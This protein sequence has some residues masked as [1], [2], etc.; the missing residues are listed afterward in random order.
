M[1]YAARGWQVVPL[2]WP[3][4]EKCSCGKADCPSPAKH[5]LTEHGLND[6]SANAQVIKAWWQRWP[7]ANVAIITGAESGLI[8]LDI[9]RKNGGLESKKLLERK[10]NFPLT[11]TVYTGGGGEHLFFRHPQNGR[12]FRNRARLGGYSGIDLRGD[13][14]YVVAVPSR[15][16]SGDSYA[17]KINP[18]NTKEV[19]AP[20]W[21]KKVIDE[22]PYRPSLAKTGTGVW[23]KLWS[24]VGEG[25]RNEVAA[26]L[27]GRL[28]GRGIAEEEAEAILRAWNIGN[29][30][31][32]TEKELEQVVL[33][34]SRAEAAKPQ[35]VGVMPAEFFLTAEI[36]R[37][38][39]I[40]AGGIIMEGSGVI[41]TG[42]SGVGKSLLTLEIAIRISKGLPLWEYEVDKPRQVLFIQKENPDYTIQTRLRRLCRGLEI[43]TVRKIHFAKRDFKADLNNTQDLRQ[44]QNLIEKLG[45]EL[46]ILDPL[47]SY[48]RVN[49]NDNIQMRQTL[50]HL[51]DISAATN[52]AW[53]I[54]HHEGKPQDGREGAWRFRGASSIRDW[55]DTM[56]GYTAKP[57]KE[58]KVL[59][60]LS[61]D[62]LRHG[63]E[64]ASLLLERDE[65]FVHQQTEDAANLVTPGLVAECLLELG[66][67]CQGKGPLVE[68]LIEHSFCSRRTAYYAIEVAENRT[69]YKSGNYYKTLVKM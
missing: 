8:V 37:P 18:D 24:G 21:L 50:D 64:H 27:A 26:K 2:H 11:P 69:I 4:G 53:L 46:V 29:R 34:I 57:N 30:P 51:T 31:P 36:D 5:P 56:L 63:P 22:D 48:H 20:D 9:D 62:K 45:A 25:E 41:L 39:S 42:A 17:W 55:A 7:K 61:F 49:E 58:G 38:P 44:M 33:S 10:G 60:L 32:M 65:N 14:G 23:A 54:V 35:A 13:G 28:I 16:I 3:E 47:S 1:A 12:K 19:L 40:V 59:R 52:C 43:K 6:S 15:H 68:K 66:G 67:S